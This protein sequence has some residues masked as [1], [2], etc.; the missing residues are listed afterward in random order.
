LGAKVVYDVHEDYPASI[1]TKP[2]LPFFIRH[3]FS[4]VFDFFE[5][6]SCYFFDAIVPATDNIS[7]RFNHSKV[8]ILHNYPIL[9]S[10][11]DTGNAD[12]VCQDNTIIYAGGLVEI[13]GI[14]EMVQSLEYIHEKWQVILKLLGKFPDAHFEKRVKSMGMY[15][16]VNF[17]GFVPLEEVH[18]HL[19]TARIGLVLFHPAPNHLKAMPNKMFEYMAAGLPVIASNFPLWKEIVETSNCGL[20]VDP[21]NPRKIA[22]TI[23]YLLESP[24][25]ME[26]MGE[27]GRK[28]VFKKY[29]WKL[30]SKKLCKLYANLMSN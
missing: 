27:N 25:L 5:R 26:E 20:T 10:A 17:L 28:A 16:K 2:W 13:R 4:N 11:T 1:R 18:S 6:G 14:C 24:E 29:N 30:E 19:S 23:K 15:P 21:M 9:H 7:K 12:S 22:S 8:V 3:L